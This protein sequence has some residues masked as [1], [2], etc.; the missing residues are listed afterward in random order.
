MDMGD[1][2]S[3]PLDDDKMWEAL[4][5]AQGKDFVESKEGQLK[6]KVSQGGQNFSGVKNNAWRLRV[7]LLVNLKL[8]SLM[9]HSQRLIIR[10]TESFVLN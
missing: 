8:S 5:L 9:I 4:D 2:N 1:S 7:P 10:L 6:A 3:S